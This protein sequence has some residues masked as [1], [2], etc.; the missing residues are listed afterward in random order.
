MPAPDLRPS[1]EALKSNALLYL[2]YDGVLSHEAVYGTLSASSPSSRLRRGTRF[3]STPHC[4]TSAGAAPWNC[5]RS[6]QVLGI[7]KAAKNLPPGLCRRVVGST[8]DCKA[9]VTTSTTCREV[10][11]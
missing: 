9:P 10:S 4:W 1:V 11:R 5:H 6:E 3:S 2:N 8:Y 7:R